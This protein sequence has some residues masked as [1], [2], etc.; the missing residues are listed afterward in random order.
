MKLTYSR[1]GDY[2]L[3]DLVLNEP[4]PEL[5]KPLGRYGRMRRAYLREH[6]TILYNTLLLS[7]KLFPHLREIDDTAS[8]RLQRG[9]PEEIILHDALD[10][11]PDLQADGISSIKGY[12]DTITPCVFR[13]S[14]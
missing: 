6:R 9:V 10:P 7:E 11:A 3:P 8:E 12:F 5:V 1:H 2:Y 14:K 13:F 4:P